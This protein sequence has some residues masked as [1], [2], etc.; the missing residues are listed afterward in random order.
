MD[1]L[2]CIGMHW[3]HQRPPQVS[4]DGHIFLKMLRRICYFMNAVSGK[5]EHDLLRFPAKA[6]FARGIAAVRE[7]Y[8][9]VGK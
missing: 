9:C 5:T 4:G 7:K 2:W 3:T 1:L 6:V 8:I